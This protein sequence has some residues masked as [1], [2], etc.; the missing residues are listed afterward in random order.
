MRRPLKLKCQLG[1]AKHSHA[2]T[3]IKWACDKLGVEAL[4]TLTLTSEAVLNGWTVANREGHPPHI[5]ILDCRSSK[6]LDVESVARSIRHGA[7]GEHVVL[8]G[9]VKKSV[10]EREEVVVETYL[11]AGFNRLLLDSGSRGYWLNEL[12]MIIHTDVEASLRLRCADLL[13]TA[14]DNCRDVVQVTDCQDRV[15]YEN[16]STEKV[17]GYSSSDWLEKCLWDYQTTVSLTESVLAENDTTASIRGSDLVRKKL[18]HGKVWEG[19][20]SLRRKAGDNIVLETRIIPVSFSAKRIPENLVYVRSPPNVLENEPQPGRRASKG[21][22]S[23]ELVAA[24][25]HLESNGYFVSQVSSTFCFDS[26][27]QPRAEDEQ[28]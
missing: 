28:L 10:M 18:D 22:L 4:G 13:L 26:R 5:I 16:N 3:A 1:I 2:S 15:I 8:I 20:L 21:G 25:N 24:A 9:I 23:K 11:Q 17:L 12:A 14:L 27:Q 7:H 19:P 6:Q